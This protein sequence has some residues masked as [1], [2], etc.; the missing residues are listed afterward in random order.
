MVII[1]L[2]GQTGSGKTTISK[3]FLQKGAFIIDVDEIARQIVYPGSEVIKS[4]ENAFGKDVINE[5]GSLNRRKLAGIVFNNEKDL[6]LLNSI[7]H[8]VLLDE[9]KNRIN[10]IRK[11]SGNSALIVVD[12]AVLIEANMTSLCDYVIVPECCQEQRIERIM[13]RDG[14]D[15]EKAIE[16]VHAQKDM[17]YFKPYANFIIDTD[18]NIENTVMQIEKIWDII[19]LA[20]ND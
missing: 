14:L 6:L 5:D 4:I 3:L 1:G 10:N 20:N 19:C 9:V 2:T 15:K 12:A 7:T 18:E 16:R 8:P 17:S 11:Q 13:E